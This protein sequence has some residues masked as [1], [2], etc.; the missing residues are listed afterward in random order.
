MVVA[1]RCSKGL[2]RTG[3]DARSEANKDAEKPI[4]ATVLSPLHTPSNAPCIRMAPFCRVVSILSCGRGPSAVVRVTE[5]KKLAPHGRV[6][7]DYCHRVHDPYPPEHKKQRVRLGHKVWDFGYWPVS[8]TKPAVPLYP[9]SSCFDLREPGRTCRCNSGS[10][11][12][13]F[14]WQTENTTDCSIC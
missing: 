8:F 6:A 9:C 5:I 11:C 4:A 2:V 3:R 1:E 7:E 10:L 13:L 12:E 14:W